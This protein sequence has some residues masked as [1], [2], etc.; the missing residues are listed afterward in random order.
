MRELAIFA[1]VYGPLHLQRSMTISG[2]L[3]ECYKVLAIF[4]TPFGSL[5][6]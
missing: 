3:V 6:R 5:S 4:P 1:Y 2:L